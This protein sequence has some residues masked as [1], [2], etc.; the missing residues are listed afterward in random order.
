MVVDRFHIVS[1]FL[2][3]PCTP[4]TLSQEAFVY[5]VCPTKIPQPPFAWKYYLSSG[6]FKKTSANKYW[7]ETSPSQLH[8]VD[9]TRKGCFSSTKYQKS[10]YTRRT[11]SF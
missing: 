9:N 10:F 5:F 8:R 4:N 2:S 7:Q 6:N 1:L 3:N 11:G